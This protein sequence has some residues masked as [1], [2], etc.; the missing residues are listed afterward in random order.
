VWRYASNIYERIT[1]V[2]WWSYTSSMH[3]MTTLVS[4]W[5]YTLS[6]YM[7]PLNQYLG[8]L[9]LACIHVTRHKTRPKLFG[10][11]IN[12]IELNSTKLPIAYRF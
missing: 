4:V 2:S 1:Y 12:P 5:I 7:Q 3:E 8:I 10:T 11:E 6:T 9:Y